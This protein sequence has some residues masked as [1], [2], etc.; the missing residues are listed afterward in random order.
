MLIQ[1]ENLCLFAL[2][3]THIGHSFRVCFCYACDVNIDFCVCVSENEIRDV[4][5][6]RKNQSNDQNNE[7][8]MK[9]GKNNILISDTPKTEVYLTL[10]VCG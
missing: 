5:Q 9:D 10:C 1:S 6:K 7:I 2:R 8:H 3:Y 4:K